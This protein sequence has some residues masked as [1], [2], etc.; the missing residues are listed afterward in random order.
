MKYFTYSQPQTITPDDDFVEI[1]ECD[2]KGEHYSARDNGAILRH[3]IPGGRKRP[4]DNKWTF[5]KKN[6]H[7]GY[8]D[9][10]GE[11][12]HRIVAT[13]FFPDK[14]G[15]E[16][17]VDHIDTNRCNNRPSNLRWCTKLENTLNNPA[18]LKK[19]VFLC[20]S[21]EKFLENP[22][23]LH[24]YEPGPNID[25][26]RTVSSEEARAAY[27][28]VKKWAEQPINRDTNT[29][30]ES[31]FGNVVLRNTQP[32]PN[33]RDDMT[34]EEFQKFR[35]EKEMEMFGV[36]SEDIG[37]P[38]DFIT[39][40]KGE[41]EYFF[42]RESS[43]PTASQ[44][45]WN[46]PTEF[47]CC[48][49]E[50]TDTPIE[51]YFNNLQ[52]DKIFCRNRYGESAVIDFAMSDD[53]KHLWVLTHAQEYQVKPWAISEIVIYNNHFLHLSRRTYFDEI[54]GRKYFTLEQGKEWTGEDCID[55]YC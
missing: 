22:S 43:T 39:N 53:K 38:K 52:I 37:K 41:Q 27:E 19:I 50:I 1:M 20:G 23:I 31:N 55:D 2:Y 47:L 10:C 11:R 28:N 33:Y 54:G 16:M 49:T 15:E 42:L 32:N 25:W 45:N 51:D 29:T 35:R 4:G 40:I 46:T 24:D 3:A 17:V 6:N 8:M 34:L 13:A 21:I 26:M 14:A 7:T 48:P 18:T 12:V 36:I 30:P 44:G 9:F 5:G